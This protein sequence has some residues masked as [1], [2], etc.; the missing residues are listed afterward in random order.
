M[1]FANKIRTSLYGRDLG[2]QSLTTPE[3]GSGNGVMR[4]LVGAVEAW[5]QA[6][7]VGGSTATNMKPAGV[8]LTN[9]GSSAVQV[10]DPPVPGVEKTIVS[11]GGSTSFV[12][13]L[14]SETLESSRGSSF[15]VMRFTQGGIVRLVGLTTARWGI[16][17]AIDSTAVCALTTTT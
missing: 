15:T 13:T 10:L 4:F 12:R 9:T 8:E 3:S 11:S 2:I 14:N 17:G 5:R 6:V 7:A 1:A 16:S